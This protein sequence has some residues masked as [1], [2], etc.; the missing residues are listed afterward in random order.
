MP[1]PPS[2]P[3]RPGAGRFPPELAGR[4]KLIADFT[5]GARYAKINGEYQRPLLLVG[6]RGMGK[7][8]LL[9]D[10]VAVARNLKL[11]VVEVEATTTDPLSVSLASGL[12]AALRTYAGLGGKISSKWK[13]A[14]SVF[15]SFQV[16][17]DPTGS[18]SFGVDVDA[19][20][21]FADTGNLSTDL[22]ELLRAV[23]DA[24]ASTYS[25]VLIA[26]DELQLA[27]EDEL[28]ALNV[29]LHR[30]GQGKEP[31]PLI[32]IGA[33]LPSLLPALADSTAYA[34]RL[35]T[36]EE[37][38]PL[39]APAAAAALTLPTVN[40][41]VKW[42]DE[43][44]K[45]AVVASRGYPFFLQEFGKAIWDVRTS[46]LIS[47]EDV[48][49][50]IDRAI[51]KLDASLYSTRWARATVAERRF[52][53]AMADDG[54]GP[55]A[56]SEIATRM[57]KSASTSISRLRASLVGKNLVFTTSRGFV[58]FTVPGMAD[59]IQLRLLEE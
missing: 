53:V 55:A 21:G 39:D 36:P 16:T 19:A 25:A 3:F 20:A 4:A 28:N 29:A 7:T 31:A 23:G 1:L 41:G 50:G 27:S 54:E 10:L 13:N 35:W 48:E 30:A 38:G 17:V 22:T 12:H 40:L 26:I 24:A 56:I 46:D 14:L 11:V 2:N 58:S 5:V 9:T 37:L 51:I 49:V 44:I 34:E 47:V 45:L 6:R 18:Y 43:A 33:G 59:Y 52:L 15:R 32:A 57:G 8:V 42:T